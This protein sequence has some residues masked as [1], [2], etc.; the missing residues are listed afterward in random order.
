[1][2]EERIFV[3]TPKGHVLDLTTGATALDFA[4]RVHTEVG[5]RC[6]GA[7]VDGRTISLNQPLESG[8]R[9]EVLTTDG[10]RITGQPD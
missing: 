1:M 9:V 5:H 6:R 2:R 10:R 3:Y 8:Q 7:R 4:Y